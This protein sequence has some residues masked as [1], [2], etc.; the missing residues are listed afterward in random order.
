MQSE[1]KGAALDSL[2]LAGVTGLE[3]RIALGKDSDKLS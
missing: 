3:A 2:E 1:C